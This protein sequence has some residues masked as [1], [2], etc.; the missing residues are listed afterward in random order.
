MGP[1]GVV[2]LSPSLDQ[3]LRLSQAGEDLT[4][5]QLVLELVWV[6]PIARAAASMVWPCATST[7]TWR[8]FATISSGVCR[9]PLI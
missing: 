2:V 7:S 9:L 1:D 3:D 6:T 4:S 8:S 5:Q